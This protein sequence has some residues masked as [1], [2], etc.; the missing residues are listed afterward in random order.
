MYE[1]HQKQLG[2]GKVFWKQEWVWKLLNIHSE[3]SAQKH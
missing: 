3:K 2:M 1:Y